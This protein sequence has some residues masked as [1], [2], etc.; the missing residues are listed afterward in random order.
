MAKVLQQTDGVISFDI[1]IDGAKIKD[2]VEIKEI[3]IVKEVNK[4]ASATIVMLDGGAIGVPDVGFDNSEGDDFVPGKKIKIAL[5]YDSQKTIVFEGLIISQGLM[6]KNGDSELRINCKDE[7][8]KMTKGRSNAIFQNKK[9]SDAISSI[10]GEYGLTIDVEATSFENPVMMQYNCNDWDFVVI[11]AE[12]NNMVVLTENNKLSIK[13]YDFS[14]PKFQINSSQFVINI[15]LNLDSENIANSYKLTAWDTKEQAIVDSDINISDN[16]N[17]G[18]LSAKK[19]SDVLGS[20]SSMHYSSA[21]LVKD[22]MKTWGQSLV[23]KAVLSKIQ[24]KITI[25]GTGEIIAGD[26]IELTAFSKRFNGNAYIS[27]VKHEVYE[28]AWITTLFVGRSNQWHAALPDVA[29]SSASGLLPASTGI[30]IAKVKKIHEDPDGEF[31]VL[32]TLPVYT[33][34]GEEDGIW[35][36]LAFPYASADAGFFFFPEVDDEVLVTFINNDPRHA[37]ITGSLY[38]SKNKSKETPDEKNQFKSIYSKSGINIRF[39]DE[40]KILTI[41]TPEKNS[42]ILDDKEKSITVQ[43]QNENKMILNDSGIELKSSK[44]ITITATGKID[45]TGEQGV[46]IKSSADVTVGGLNIELS[47]E[48]GMTAKGNAS[49]EISASGQTTVKGAMVMIN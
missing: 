5:G 49:A 13:K 1:F 14:T 2:T 11:R 24:G 35:A 46:N 18:N 19:L 7:A 6:V 17:Q 45:L 12:A 8:V 25:P 38:S 15:D 48:V 40:D 9:D 34:T 28:G 4:I 3:S 10:S 47:A 44:D 31:R 30:Q 27:K 37:I 23:N 16:L 33:G 36:R 32:I 42:F 29:E 26:V 22:E 43:D 41:E 39:D 21:L 20:K